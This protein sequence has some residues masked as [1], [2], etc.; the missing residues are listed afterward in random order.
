VA[1]NL[2]FHLAEPETAAEAEKLVAIAVAELGPHS[3]ILDTRGV[4]RLAAGKAQEA[5]A[6]L[7][8]A[9]LMPTA[10]KYLH[11]ASALASQDQLDAA[12]QAFAE[13]KKLGWVTGR[14]SAGDQQ[15]LRDLEAA[16]AH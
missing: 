9:I 8:E 16:L 7:R 2:A 15:R 4:V 5:T 3:D 11:L 14:L 1:N 13:A 6:D 10:A 12:R